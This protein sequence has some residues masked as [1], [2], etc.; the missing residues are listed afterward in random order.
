MAQ[1]S[2][3][4]G[5]GGGARNLGAPPIEVEGKDQRKVALGASKDAMALF[6]EDE[7]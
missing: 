2:A 3:S 7:Y 6:G 4:G 5:V 1:G